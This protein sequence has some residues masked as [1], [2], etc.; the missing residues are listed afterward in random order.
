MDFIRAE[1]QN[2]ALASAAV[3][4]N[5]LI[6]AI[7]AVFVPLALVQAGR[8]P[9][10]GSSVVLTFVTDGMGFFLFLTLAQL[11]LL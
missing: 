11:F 7:V 1:S 9:A 3:L 5:L 2:D 6:A 10:Q 4:L 8:D